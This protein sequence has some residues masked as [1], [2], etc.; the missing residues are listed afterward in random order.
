MAIL[1]IEN[2]RHLF[3]SDLVAT[4]MLLDDV[5][6]F[7]RQ[8]P[9]AEVKYVNTIVEFTD[10]ATAI[11]ALAPPGIS[12]NPT[13]GYLPY[14]NAG[15]FADSHLFQNLTDLH[16]T[17]T[18]FL[19][20]ANSQIQQDFGS[21]TYWKLTT[22]AGIGTTGKFTVSPTQ[23]IS[24]LGADYISTTAASTTLLHATMIDFNSA[25][26]KFSSA[27]FNTVPYFDLFSNLVSSTV[28]PIEL[29]YLSGATSN[30]QVQINALGNGWSLLGNAG[31]IDGTNFIGTTDNVPLSFRVNNIRA[32]K[33]DLNNT[34]LGYFSSNFGTTGVGNIAIGGSS[35]GSITTG[36]YN[37]ASGFQA[38]QFNTISDYNVAYGYASLTNNTT[39]T[40]NTAIG[41]QSLM[42]NVLGNS[43]TSVGYRTLFLNTGSQNTAIGSRALSSSLFTNFNT[44]IGANSLQ[45]NTASEN[46]AV[47]FSSLQNNTT[48][49]HNVGIGYKA[50][51]ISTI[52]LSNTAV[53]W[54]AL[55]FT[56]TGSGNTAI[57][58][59]V[60]GLNTTGGSNTVVGANSMI[61]NTTGS[62][63]TAIGLSVL[64]ASTT[65]TGNV[66]IG[67]G[68]SGAIVSGGF[69]TVIGFGAFATA[70]TGSNN[71]IVGRTTGIGITTGI[72]NTIIGSQVSGLAGGLSNNVILANGAG[73]IRL[74][75]DNTGALTLT[76]PSVSAAPSTASTD[77]I[78]VV[79]GGTTYY[80]LAT[81]IP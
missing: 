65:A 35:L 62:S 12:V 71:T 10:L 21:G 7:C 67:V 41:T 40:N 25:L 66:S 48:G 6:V 39:G 30:I 33:I 42:T 4:N 31:T 15:V 75:F 77:K 44:A 49:F 32:G 45:F 64:A 24:Q 79:V 2:T 57:G 28:T 43:N 3:L 58:D 16:I 68:S 51:N 5:F 26:Y 76:G 56:T 37:T 8:T 13:S 69:N 19:S 46:T 38:L 63:N 59:T 14:N 36:S 55:E 18:K 1:P 20:S 78:Q 61:A 11:N 52:A 27:S 80:L 53:G 54:G 22:D 34:S 73:T 60:L 9:L 74:Q 70:I 23:I 17:D 72:Q 29:N 50:L 81:T 47:G